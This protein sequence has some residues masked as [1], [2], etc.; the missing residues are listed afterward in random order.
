M[1]KISISLPDHLLTYLDQKVDN[2]SALIEFLIEQW[3]RQ[4]EDEA[5]AQACALVDE[6]DL[7]WDDE[8]QDKAITDWKASGS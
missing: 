1:A 5:L 6:L 2:C 3:R 7:G 8:W 4:Q